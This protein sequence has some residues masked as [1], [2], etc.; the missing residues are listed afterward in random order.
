MLI[1]KQSTRYEVA[2]LWACSLRGLFHG[3]TVNQL[4]GYQQTGSLSV[5]C[6]HF[7]VNCHALVCKVKAKNPEFFTHMKAKNMII[8]EKL[9]R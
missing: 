3:T 9:R 5:Q 1:K 4:I 6:I 7:R 8:E 2:F